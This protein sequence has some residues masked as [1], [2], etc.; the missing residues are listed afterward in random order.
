MV[1]HTLDRWA[2]NFRVML[3]SIATLASHNV[4]LVSVTENIDYSTPQGMLFTQMLGSF[5]QYFSDSLGTH[6]SKGLG[7]RQSRGVIP[8]AYPSNTS[9]AERSLGE[10]GNRSA[11]R[12]ML[13]ACTSI[14]GSDRRLESYSAAALGGGG[15]VTL[16]TLASWLN[17][18]GFRTRNTKKLPDGNGNHVAG[19]RLFTN[20]SVR[21][22]LHNPF[23][24]G[25]IR[26]RHQTLPGAH[27]GLVSEDVFE[28][29]GGD[30]AQLG[31]QPHTASTARA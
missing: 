23:Y 9:R 25:R 24:M 14:L 10:R 16:A 6:V 5:A 27:D 8:E 12:S 31:A 29:G 2:R 21:N 28:T 30:A 26:H 20:A 7:Q 15:S 18:E 1:V 19:P 22:I 4:A 17:E 3:E 13:A 11:S